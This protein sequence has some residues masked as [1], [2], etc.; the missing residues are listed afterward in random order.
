MYYLN[1]RYYD[2]ETGRFVNA[3]RVSILAIQKDLC[4]RNL[5]VYC[6]NNPIVREDEKGALWASV[7]I[8]V[9]TQYAGDVIGNVLHGKK[10]VDIFKPTSTIGEYISAG[11]TAL[12]PGSGRGAAFCAIAYLRG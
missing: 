12:I 5:Y 6:D 4:D 1:S 9:A 8:G 3:D 11:V 7:A 2:P 10:G